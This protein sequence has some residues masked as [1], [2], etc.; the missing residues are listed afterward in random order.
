MAAEIVTSHRVHTRSR[1]TVVVLNWNGWRDT[2]GCLASLQT[3]VDPQPDILLID[4]RSTDDSVRQVRQSYPA[5]RIV[6]NDVNLGFG[7]GCNVGLREALASDCE[8]VWLI[9]NDARVLPDTLEKMLEVADRRPAVGAVGSVIR[10]VDK[11]Q[12]VQVWGGG[13]VNMCLGRSRLLLQPGQLDFVS[14]ASM[15]I[16]TEALRSVGLFDE[17]RYFMYW[18]DTD[19]SFR[20]RKQGWELV[21]SSASQVFH[22]G[23]ASLGK[24]SAKIDEYFICSAARFFRQH[25]P[26]PWIPIGLLTL[27]LLGKRILLRHW[28]RVR[29]VLSG[30]RRGFLDT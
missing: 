17:A 14:G 7:G 5:L 4:N 2:L 13:Q 10:N 23:S 30:L 16:R 29:S 26:L 6:V 3:L 18:E 1:V 9:N 11:A 12:T 20:M 21:A 15:L 19:L 8:Y 27:S 25:A 22:I 24:G 28:H